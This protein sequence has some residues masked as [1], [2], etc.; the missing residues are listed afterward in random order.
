MFHHF[1]INSKAP[2]K[3]PIPNGRNKKTLPVAKRFLKVFLLFLFPVLFLS[4]STNRLKDCKERVI[5]LQVEQVGN[6][7]LPAIIC[8]QKIYFSVSEVFELL[9]HQVSAADDFSSLDVFMKDEEDSFRLEKS[10]N[11]IS[12]RGLQI[13]LEKEAIKITKTNLFLEASYFEDIFGLK[14]SFNFSDL[15]VSMKVDPDAGLS[16]ETISGKQQENLVYEVLY[17]P[18]NKNLQDEEEIDSEKSLQYTYGK[19]DTYTEADSIRE[20]LREDGFPESILVP[21]Y[22]NREISLAEALAIEQ[23]HKTIESP[24]VQKQHVKQENPAG[25]GISYKVQVLASKQ[26][27]A[28][29]DPA[30]KNLQDLSSYVH[31]GMYKYTWSEETK[32]EKARLHQN[33]LRAGNF[34]DAFVVHFKNGKRIKPVIPKSTF[35]NRDKKQEKG[36]KFRVQVLASNPKLSAANPLFRNLRGIEE[37]RHEGMYK[38]TR[39]ASTSFGKANELKEQLRKK[40]FPDAFVVPFYD[41]KRLEQWQIAGRV[42]SQTGKAEGIEGINIELY[43]FEQNYV[44]TV[45]SENDGYFGISN[46]GPGNYT[47]QL[48][49][50]QL[51]NLQMTTALICSDIRITKDSKAGDHLQEFILKSGKE[52]WKTANPLP[53]LVFKVQVA[54]SRVKL[55]SKHPALKNRKDIEMYEDEG[56]YKYTLGET[57]LMKEAE[58]LMESLQ[59][60]GFSQAFVVPFINGKRVRFEEVIILLEKE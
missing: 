48:N 40:G 5:L 11:K 58:Q 19:A 37:H 2:V 50:E 7:L 18:R 57:S 21:L 53:G 39:G 9:G 41:G 20:M 54:A 43:D 34:P 44:A 27:I 46:L 24:T 17:Y 12:F 25:K 51:E 23:K 8:D 22:D 26:K 47:L 42:S 28:A 29:G 3:K 32:L 59:A 36:W 14:N 6:T 1:F 33:K 49:E 30:F 38:Y 52:S 35:I 45:I 13:N 56:M 15:L 31:Q 60:E 16:K 10:G 4:G 55:S